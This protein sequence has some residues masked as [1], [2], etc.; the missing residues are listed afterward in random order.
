ML[1]K[2]QNKKKKL[3]NTYLSSFHL[4]YISG[5]PLHEPVAWGGPIV[6]NTQE[7]LEKAFQELTI[8]SFIK[9]SPPVKPATGFYRN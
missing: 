2:Q 5:K 8:G 3:P 4:L 6:M 9:H 7:Q 1:R